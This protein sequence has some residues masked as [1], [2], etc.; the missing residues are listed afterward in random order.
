MKRR[1]VL[2]Q[3]AMG[4]AGLPT[5]ASAATES[6]VDSARA[7]PSLG[8]KA[9]S[10]LSEIERNKILMRAAYG[11]LQRHCLAPTLSDV[12]A[13]TPPPLASASTVI[14]CQDPPGGVDDPYSVITAIGGWHAQS[15]APA[16]NSYGPMIAEGNS[17]IEEWEVFMHGVDG[18]MYNNQYCWIKE[19]KDGQ[20][21][22]V[23]E[24]IDSHHAFIVLGL[25]APW[26]ALEPPRAPRRHWRPGQS[27]LGRPALTE[28]ETIFPI[29]QEFEL[30]PQLL[31]D[32]TP[33]A[34]PPKIFP[35]TV[36]GNKALVRAMR[37][38]QA[39]GDTAAVDSYH[40]KEYRHFIAG[41][42]PF[43]WE[44]LPL[45][46]LY[47]PLVKH[48]ASPIRV[49]FGHMV[50]EDGR[51]FEEMDALAHLDD[52]T[53][54]NN[55]HCFIHEIRGGRIVQTREYLDTHHMWVV[56]GRWADWGTVPVPPLRKARRSN[57]PYPTATYQVKNPF[58]KLERWEPLPLVKS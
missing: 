42:G 12:T 49:R 10:S 29:R 33:T 48:L 38:A 6:L 24:Y 19:V 57:M 52:G 35:D 40:G 30:K 22:A 50:C 21:V 34:N 56:L 58:L 18:T 53:V 11:E 28:I 14:S 23:R 13:K 26:K 16:I 3:A 15:T 43:G 44:H 32:I 1:Q 37:D 45:Q 36:E 46:D 51:V 7:D 27:S 17:V 39:K 20:I 54:Y 5:L 8:A 41:E 9:D 2:K 4:L 55:W 25:H 47:A 31:R